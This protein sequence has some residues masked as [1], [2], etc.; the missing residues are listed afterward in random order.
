MSGNRSRAGL[1]RPLCVQPAEDDPLGAG[2]SSPV[3]NGG[4]QLSVRKAGPIRRAER[5]GPESRL[6]GPRGDRESPDLAGVLTAVRLAESR[7]GVSRRRGHVR[8]RLPQGV[9]R[10]GP[11][12][13]EPFLGSET[14]KGRGRAA[15]GAGGA[16]VLGAALSQLSSRQR[17]LLFVASDVDALCACK[18]LQVRPA[19]WAGEGRGG[20]GRREGWSGAGARP[21]AGTPARLRPGGDCLRWVRGEAGRRHSWARNGGVGETGRRGAPSRRWGSR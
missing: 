2:R 12:P 8:V 14:G 4:A 17:V 15:V 1:A 19:G 7:P 13:G 20:R 5:R 21:G 11:E 6:A 18:I 3:V 16:G 9:L 10:G